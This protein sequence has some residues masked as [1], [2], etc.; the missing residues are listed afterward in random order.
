MGNAST[1][2]RRRGRRPERQ[3]GVV[4]NE[5]LQHTPTQYRHKRGLGSFSRQY[6]AVGWLYGWPKVRPA[7]RATATASLQGDAVQLGAGKPPG[8]AAEGQVVGDLRRPATQLTRGDDR[9][10]QP[11]SEGSVPGVYERA[12]SGPAGPFAAVSDRCGAVIRL[13]EPAFA[14]QA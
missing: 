6:S 10:L 4:R 5:E 2:R 8:P 11:K 9:G 7:D 1:S 13:G 12:R 14:K 3:A